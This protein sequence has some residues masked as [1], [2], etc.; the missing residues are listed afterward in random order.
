M[1]YNWTY[2]KYDENVISELQGFLPDKIFD[3]HAHIY[4][5]ADLNMP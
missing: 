5:V 2:N 4:R 1:V 3:M